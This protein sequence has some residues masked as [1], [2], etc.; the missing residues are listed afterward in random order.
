MPII[1]YTN[2]HRYGLAYLTY[3]YVLVFCRGRDRSDHNVATDVQYI[4]ETKKTNK[5]LSLKVTAGQ[6]SRWCSCVCTGV[7]PQIR[8]D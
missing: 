4:L 5:G 6:I 3:T 7:K 8:S 1:T 2:L